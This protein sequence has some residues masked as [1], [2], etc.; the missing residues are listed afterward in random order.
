MTGG[1]LTPMPRIDLRAARLPTRRTVIGFG[2]SH[3]RDHRP[4]WRIHSISSEPRVILAPRAVQLMYN[5]HGIG[6]ALE[7]YRL[8][9]GHYPATAQG[10]IALVTRPA[11]HPFNWRGPYGLSRVP[12]DPWGRP[13]G[14]SRADDR[15]GEAFVLWSY[16]ADRPPGGT[17]ANADVVFRP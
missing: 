14:Y 7:M 6:T 4:P 5:M 9:T 2:H 11:S 16:G 15:T 12:H 8:D 13:Y 1:V 3:L 10:L 17:G